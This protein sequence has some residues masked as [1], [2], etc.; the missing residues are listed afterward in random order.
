MKGKCSKCKVNQAVGKY[1]SGVFCNDCLPQVQP[2][3]SGQDIGIGIRYR[4]TSR[5]RV[6]KGLKG[7]R[8]SKKKQK[9][10]TNMGMVRESRR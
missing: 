6:L 5:G 7:N 1:K 3:D 10:R 8:N 4:E 9:M 2:S